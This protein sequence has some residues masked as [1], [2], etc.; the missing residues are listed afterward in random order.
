MSAVRPCH[1]WAQ[2]HLLMG[3]IVETKGGGG[4]VGG[5]LYGAWAVVAPGRAHEASGFGTSHIQHC[6]HI[7]E[8]TSD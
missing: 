2:S 1:A 7:V 5:L 3:R 8:R 6:Y 4:G